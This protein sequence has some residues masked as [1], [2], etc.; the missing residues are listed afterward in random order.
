MKGIDS[1]IS[2]LVCY[3]PEILMNQ[4]FPLT[5]QGAPA[6]I[7]VAGI[8][9]GPVGMASSQCQQYNMTAQVR[10]RS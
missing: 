5:V 7:K 1:G 2:I 6:N 9:A 3:L 4:D 10:I 8:C